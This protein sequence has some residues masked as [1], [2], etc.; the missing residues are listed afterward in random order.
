MYNIC[1]R[2]TKH[3]EEECIIYRQNLYRQDMIL[4]IRQTIFGN[5]QTWCAPC[6]FW[7]YDLV[8]TCATIDIARKTEY[9]CRLIECILRSG[10]IPFEVDNDETFIRLWRTDTRRS[11]LSQILLLMLCQHRFRNFDDS[12]RNIIICVIRESDSTRRCFESCRV[13]S[14]TVF[15]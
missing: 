14:A 12:S 7:C 15:D 5:T 8:T 4:D 1:H 10:E 9:R 3:P 2:C 6:L 11:N 13:K